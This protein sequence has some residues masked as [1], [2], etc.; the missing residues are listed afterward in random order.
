MSNLPEK[1]KKAIAGPYL[2]SPSTSGTFSSSSAET[3]KALDPTFQA[4]LAGGAHRANQ[5]QTTSELT[6]Q[7]SNVSSIALR[8]CSRSKGCSLPG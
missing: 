8:L 7:R 3:E 1:V 4:V 5:G 2:R 6:Q